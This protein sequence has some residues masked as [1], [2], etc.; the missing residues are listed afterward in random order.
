MVPLVSVTTCHLGD[1]NC[2]SGECHNLSNCSEL[3]WEVQRRTCVAVTTGRIS[4]P[5]PLFQPLSAVIPCSA[6]PLNL[7]CVGPTHAQG[8][9]G[10]RRWV[11]II[12]SEQA[13]VWTVL[14][15]NS[16][17]SKLWLCEVKLV[18][19]LFKETFTNL[20]T[21]VK[22]CWYECVVVTYSTHYY[23]CV[24]VTYSTRY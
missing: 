22:V 15:C 24:V 9:M 18:V 8:L 16:A 23:E 20:M 13:A 4:S 7:T 5:H 1:V 2:T 6:V 19:V 14:N 21:T 10:H 11:H 17:V 3:E 12:T